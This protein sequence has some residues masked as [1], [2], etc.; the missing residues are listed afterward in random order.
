MRNTFGAGALLTAAQ[1]GVA[2]G[3]SILDWSL[4]LS[5]IHGWGQLLT[6]VAFIFAAGVVGGAVLGWQSLR[7][8]RPASTF[9]TRVVAVVS[10]G[11][12]SA[13][14]LPL[15]WIPVR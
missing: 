2:S 10:A 6:W 7:R 1:V 3:L 14:A 12:G 9:W 5:T 8:A 11:L 13:I 15:V 4:G